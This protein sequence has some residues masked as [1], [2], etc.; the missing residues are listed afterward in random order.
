MKILHR[1]PIAALAVA[2]A[3]CAFAHATLV[4][5]VPAKGATLDKPPTELRLTF[6]ERIEPAFTSVTVVDAA[7]H[8]VAEAKAAADPKDAKSASFA[9]PTLG[10]GAYTAR[11]NAVGAD[12]HKTHGE[13][14]F[15]VR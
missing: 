15:S 14:P 2:V 6:N 4:A 9:V 1:L 12:G 3:P 13:L 10:S 11:W 5:S 8:A 7:G